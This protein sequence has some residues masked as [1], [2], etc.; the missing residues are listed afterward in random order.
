M[1]NLIEIILWISFVGCCASN[2]S[3]LAKNVIWKKSSTMIPLIGGLTGAITIH[4]SYFNE[5]QNY[6]WVALLLDMSWLLYASFFYS[7]IAYWCRFRQ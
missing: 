4:I 2:F 5:I 1:K 6:W 3:S 7:K